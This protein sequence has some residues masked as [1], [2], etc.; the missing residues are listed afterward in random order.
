AVTFTAVKGL[1]DSRC[2]S[3]RYADGRFLRHASWRLRLNPDVG[4]VLFRGDATFCPRPGAVPGSVALE[5]SNYPGWFLRHRGDE[6]W[7]DQSDG[8]AAFLADGSFRARP[9]LTR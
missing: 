3:F 8:S 1:A 9:P 4:T 6:L 2:V 7:V 5:S